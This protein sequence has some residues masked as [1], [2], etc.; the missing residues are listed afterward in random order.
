MTNKITKERAIENLEQ[1]KENIPLA[2]RYNCKT[3]KPT[4]L[5]TKCP[6]ERYRIPF[7]SYKSRK[8]STSTT[9]IENLL[10]QLSYLLRGVEWVYSRDFKLFH[11][12]KHS[13][14]KNFILKQYQTQLRTKFE[15]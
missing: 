2:T 3:P 12:N 15:R 11:F 1:E 4:N 8:I 7:N 10:L 6:K 9:T 13:P 5:S 14:F